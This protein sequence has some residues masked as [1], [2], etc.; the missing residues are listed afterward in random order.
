MMLLL[1][2]LSSL[3]AGM[4]SFDGGDGGGVGGGGDHPLPP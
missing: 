1:G 2:L 3:V 4:G